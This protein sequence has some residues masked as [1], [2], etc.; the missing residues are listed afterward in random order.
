[1][2]FLI[3]TGATTS[4]I[5]PGICQPKFIQP[6]ERPLQV[7][8]MTGSREIVQRAIIPKELFGFPI[9]QK[10]VVFHVTPFHETL[11]G[12]IASDI[13]MSNNADICFSEKCIRINGQIV[14]LYFHPDEEPVG[15]INSC[16]I[17]PQPEL[18]CSADFQEDLR[19]DHLKPFEI[20]KNQD[21]D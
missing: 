19:F 9:S 20:Q 1:M 6:I 5:N 4:I 2:R 8:T 11:N 21:I 18:Y 3:D 17:E 7:R 16:V 13:L 15:E 12:L 14:P 10:E